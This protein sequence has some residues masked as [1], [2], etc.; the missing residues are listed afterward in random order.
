MSE[1]GKIR[2]RLVER[3]TE[4]RS[5]LPTLVGAAAAFAVGA[6]VILAWNNL[7]SPIQWSSLLPGLSDSKSRPSF[8]GDRVGR[9]TTA[10]LLKICLTKDLL[11]IDRGTEID[12]GLLLQILEAGSTQGRVTR[13]LGAPREHAA[14]ELAVTWGSVTDCVYHQNTWN[15]C[16]I[17]N[18]AL[19]IDS[20]N[21]FVRQ[22]DEIIAASAAY[23]VKPGEI[24]ELSATKERV[25]QSLRERVHD[26]LLIAAD[27]GFF[28]PAAVKQVLKETEP[29]QNGCSKR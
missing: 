11:G 26:G 25:L 17:D 2:A 1:F 5:V 10:P 3:P 13:V 4:R 9:A 12:P 28:P 21:T 23:T 29:V 7:P 6:L 22:A 15:L 19:A 20:A 8:S 27:F 16:D 14:L 24:S 18:R